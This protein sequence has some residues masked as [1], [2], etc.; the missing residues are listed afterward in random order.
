MSGQLIT[1]RM[2]RGDASSPWGFRL[3]GG[4][5]WGTPLA[6]SKI[7]PGSLAEQGG[8]QVGDFI[9]KIGNSTAQE[10]LHHE[11]QEAIKSA[12]NNLD[13]QVQRGGT[14]TWRPTVTAVGELPKPGTVNSPPTTTYTKTSLA[15][16][17]P[18]PKPIGTGHNTAAK[19]FGGNKRLPAL[20]HK[21]FNSPL[22][23]YS[24]TNIK[25]TLQAHTEQLAPGVM[26]INFMKPDAPVNKHSAVY[27]AILEEEQSKKEVKSGTIGTPTP[28]SPTNSPRLGI[29]SITKHVDAPI[30]RGSGQNNS[31]GDNSQSSLNTCGQCGGLITG[32]FCRIRDKSLHAECFKCATC[33]TSLKNVGYFNVNEKLYCDAHAGQAAQH[34]AQSTGQSNIEPMTI[35]PGATIP[36]DANIIGIGGIPT[37]SSPTPGKVSSPRITIPSPT[38]PSTLHDRPTSPS[39]LGAVPWHHQS[40]GNIHHVEAPQSPRLLQTTTPMMNQFSSAPAPPPVAPKPQYKPM[41]SQSPN[42]YQSHPH[43][44]TA[45]SQD[46]HKDVSGGPKFTWPPPKPVTPVGTPEVP[47]A[48]L[49]GSISGQ[50][51]TP[52]GQPMFR[53]LSGNQRPLSSFELSKLTPNATSNVNLPSG[54]VS[55]APTIGQSSIPGSRPAPRRGMGQLKTQVGP[56]ARIPICSTCGSPIRGPFI[57]ASEKTWCLE[58]FLCANASCRRSLEDIGFVEERGELYC[59]VCFESYLAPVCAK[60]GIR[61][62]KDCLMAL[63]KQWHPECFNCNYCR[64]PFGNSQFYLEDGLPYCEKDWNDLFTTKCTACGF[65]I[66]AGDRWLEACNNNY[67]STCF[68]CNFCHKNLDGQSFFA[69]GGRPFCRSHAR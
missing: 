69:K 10:M 66:E 38:Q 31:S 51:G 43:P 19:P 29:G 4:K 33:G 18:E 67:H 47:S 11:A 9:I 57:L 59:E 2:N 21:Q 17:G 48:N 55:S 52:T 1:V 37:N 54:N 8:L 42:L 68:K 34:L 58:H 44:Y 56:G 60:C 14:L 50:T 41:G 40:P 46:V 53:P 12:K 35:R 65:P 30:S 32:V 62:K 20:V 6:V 5:D 49:P 63:E 39:V 24:E 23:L 45:P 3:Q 16:T 61:I 25:E 26:G 36:K 13:L 22:N 64:R 28:I 15:K 7:N 27:Q